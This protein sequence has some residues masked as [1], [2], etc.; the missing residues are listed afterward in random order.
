[1]VAA[2]VLADV[3]ALRRGR[4]W[5]G[6]GTG[7]AAAIK[8]TPGLF[9]VY[10]VVTRRWRTTAIAA[11]TVGITLLAGFAVDPSG[12]YWFRTLWQTDRVG[13][14]S[15]PNNQSLLGLLARP[16]APGRAGTGLRL[17]LAA[18]ALVI[19]IT[20]AVLLNRRGDD[21]AGI[22]VTGLT[23]CLISPISWLH[24]L[25]WVVPAVVV[26]VD[27]AAGTPVVAVKHGHRPGLSE[28]LPQAPPSSSSGLSPAR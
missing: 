13:P 4:P 22:T 15:D 27:V 2:L 23:A 20:R 28:A 3:Q 26:L 1:M 21:L 10:L 8:V 16:E 6:V 14:P 19:G 9:L 17:V 7:L 11:I 25:Y 24:H 5:A 18:L 12:R